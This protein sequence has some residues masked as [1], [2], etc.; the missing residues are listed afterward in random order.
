MISH[1]K[2]SRSLY[3]DFVEN[4][5]LKL[6]TIFTCLYCILFQKNLTEYDYFVHRKQLLIFC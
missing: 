6:I 3:N 5:F 1:G 2:F 4:W